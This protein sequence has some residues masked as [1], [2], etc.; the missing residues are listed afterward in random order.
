MKNLIQLLVIGIILNAHG[1]QAQDDAR[2][3]IKQVVNAAGGVQ[4]LR[5]LKDVEY[6][7]TF[8]SKE[9]GIKDVSIERYIFDG[10]Y[11]FAN[12]TTREYYVLP[13]MTGSMTQY[14]NGVKTVSH[15]EGQLITDE[16]AAYVG[17]FFRKTNF[18]WFSM[19]YKLLDPGVNLKMMDDRK[20][21]SVSYK[22]VEM[23]F[24]DGIG[25]T[26][27]RYVL[28]INPK[29]K[30]IDQFLFTVLGFGFKE[31]FIM[32]MEYEEVDGLMLS[33]YR[34]YAPANWQGEVIKQE[35]NEE[36][37]RKIKFNNGFTE[38]S[39]TKI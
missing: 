37:S 9:K 30:M 38:S 7:Y 17:H 12:Y 19:M 10:E 6:E 28:Y 8:R 26:S 21:G 2:P 35:W 13:K 27:D 16:Q 1:L 4:K 29:T 33:T 18:Y 15:H 25:E 24:G 3:L 32:K 36:I 5:A 14:Y 23:T 20:V 22:I 31:P 34:A 39:I 11:S